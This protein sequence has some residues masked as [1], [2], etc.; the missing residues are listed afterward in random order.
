MRARRWP[1]TLIVAAQCGSVARTHFGE[2]PRV[3]F[4]ERRSV[5]A[6]EHAAQ[7]HA[8][9]GIAE[10]AT[11][12][13]SR[14]EEILKAHA[15]G[16]R[17][18]AV[19]RDSVLV[20]AVATNLETQPPQLNLLWIHPASR[21]RRTSVE[22]TRQVLGALF[23]AHQVVGVWQPNKRMRESLV[24]LGMNPSHNVPCERLDFD[25]GELNLG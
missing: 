25:R 2:H 12:E 19:L 7:C 15:E 13:A 3:H 23:K 24:E 21:D 20:G 5:F 16:R 8:W 11:Q 17:V 10:M 18:Y 14:I 9:L 6:D 1:L 4:G 22:A